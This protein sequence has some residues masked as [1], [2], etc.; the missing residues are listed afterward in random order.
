[1]SQRARLLARRLTKRSF[2][3]GAVLALAVAGQAEPATDA[4]QSTANRTECSY[5]ASGRLV[6][7]PRGVTCPTFRAPPAAIAAEP[8]PYLPEPIHDKL[9][10][11]P[12]AKTP[13]VSTAPASATP[14]TPR[15]ELAALLA[16]R[17]RLDA[18]LARVREAFAYEDREAARRVV[19]ESLA[20]IARHLEREARVL[21]PLL[22]SAN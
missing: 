17:E 12:A 10:R 7:A 14:Q 15:A 19:E 1:M 18:E 6:F 3:F 16:E 8:L 9:A 5:G 11:P 20:K 22:A 2:A 21:Q 4:A 13:P